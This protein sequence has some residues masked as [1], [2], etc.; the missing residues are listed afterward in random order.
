MQGEVV[1]TNLFR[2]CL[3][4]M[5]HKGFLCL[6]RHCPL[7]AD[8]T[9]GTFS[10]HELFLS[11]QDE[12]LLSPLTWAFQVQ[13]LLVLELFRGTSRCFVGP[14][15]R[16]GRQTRSYLPNQAGA[17]SQGMWHPLPHPLPKRSTE[18]QGGGQR[19]KGS[20]T[21]ELPHSLNEKLC[22][23]AGWTETQWSKKRDSISL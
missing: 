18:T 20:K 1:R 4:V 10:I 5:F 22:I 3:P 17:G 14:D 23:C 2:L 21:V 16:T 7:A 12:L 13:V 19:F 6:F 8:N 11:H 15:F 9:V